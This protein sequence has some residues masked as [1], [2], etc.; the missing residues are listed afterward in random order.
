MSSGLHSTRTHH[1][2]HTGV[3]KNVSAL[4]QY[5]GNSEVKVTLTYTYDVTYS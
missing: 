4:Q 3:F 5:G 1:Q 2:I